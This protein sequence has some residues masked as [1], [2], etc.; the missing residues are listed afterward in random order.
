M[1]LEDSLASHSLVDTIFLSSVDGVLLHGVSSVISKLAPAS[2][3]VVTIIHPFAYFCH[4]CFRQG[5]CPMASLGN[6]MKQHL[7]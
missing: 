5:E 4:R 1:L 7:K 3:Q 2:E 6:K